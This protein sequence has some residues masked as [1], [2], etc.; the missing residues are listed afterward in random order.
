MK[1]RYSLILTLF[2]FVFLFQACSTDVDLYADY[3]DI[4]IV[5]GLLDP[6][7]DT[8]YIKINKAF[9]G[10]A[11]VISQIADSCNYPGKLDV[12]LIEYRANGNSTN[13]EKTREFAL[14]TI[15][16]HNKDL[17]AFYAPDQ[18]V[19]FTNYKIHANNDFYKYR[20]DLRI[21]RGDTLITSST[22]VVGGKNFSMSPNTIDYSS[23]V[24]QGTLKWNEC[25]NTAIFELDVYFHYTE[26][27]PSNDSVEHVVHIWS[28]KEVESNIPKKNGIYNVSFPHSNFFTNIGLDVANS[29]QDL[30]IQRIFFEPSIEVVIS[31]GGDELNN[32]IMVNGANNSIVQNIPEYS[33]IIG[34]YGVFSSRTQFVHRARLSTMTVLEF[35]Q[36]HPEWNFR[37]GQ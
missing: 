7:L 19:Y 15:T 11:N 6:N 25:P 27:G 37:Q 36:Q 28:Y 29:S 23:T 30:N 8:N 26:V 18:L 12:R 32:Y 31:A 13:Y 1:K 4:T 9:L 3:K 22:F 10:D 20:Y 14:D 21:D 24:D 5:Y 16:V 34:G 35:T 33:N 17:G 2:A